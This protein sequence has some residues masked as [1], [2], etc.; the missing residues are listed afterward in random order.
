MDK[1]ANNQSGINS[2]V[3]QNVTALTNALAWGAVAQSVTNN[4]NSPIN[5]DQTVSSYAVMFIGGF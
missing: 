4:T 5:G 3:Q 2:Q 1:G